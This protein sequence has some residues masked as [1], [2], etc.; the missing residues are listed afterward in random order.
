C[1]DI[2]SLVVAPL[3]IGLGG[4][5]KVSSDASDADNDALSFQWSATASVFN[6]P[7]GKQT[8]YQC[9][10]PGVQT[11]TITVGDAK[12]CT[13][14]VSADV[15][16]IADVTSCGN[17]IVELGEECDPPTPGLCSGTC[18]NIICECGDGFMCPGKQCEP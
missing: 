14:A 18:Q 12:G 13:S 15:D 3:S 7:G 17:H 8:Q 16:C 6:N 11:L 5:I 9:A 1:P 4:L 2:T 10:V